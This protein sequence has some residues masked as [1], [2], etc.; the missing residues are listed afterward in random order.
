VHTTTKLLAVAAALAGAAATQATEIRT[1]DF[2]ASTDLPS[3]FYV[4]PFVIGEINDGIVSDQAPYNGFASNQIT[5]GRITFSFLQAWDLTTL[6][7]W[8]D[9]NVWNEGVRSFRLSFEDAAGALLGSTGTFAAVSQLAPQSYSFAS[10][11][12][13]KRVHMDVL[14]AVFQIE[15]REVTFDGTA[16]AVPEPGAWALMGLGLAGVAAAVRRRRG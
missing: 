5:T 4:K 14:S 6:T 13:V 16:A 11:A 10:V 12:G 8:N 1:T 15:V 7:L 3:Y 2:V 9:V